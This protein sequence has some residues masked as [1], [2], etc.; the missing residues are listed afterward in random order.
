MILKDGGVAS[1]GPIIHAWI[2]NKRGNSEVTPRQLRGNFLRDERSL[3]W[4]TGIHSIM[5]VVVKLQVF[6]F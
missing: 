1:I 4:V 2:F 3:N 6:C 5:S